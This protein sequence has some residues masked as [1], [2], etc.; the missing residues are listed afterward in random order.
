MAPS[1]ALSTRQHQL[2]VPAG[3][4]QIAGGD[5]R[6]TLGPPLTSLEYSTTIDSSFTLTV[7]VSVTTTVTTTKTVT[8]DDRSHSEESQYF[9]AASDSTIWLGGERPATS[10]ELTTTTSTA[11][12]SPLP[13]TSSNHTRVL[14]TGVLHGTPTKN[15]TDITVTPRSRVPLRALMATTFVPS[16]LQ[17]W[18]ESSQ[19]AT[20]VHG[21]DRHSSKITLISTGAPTIVTQMVNFANQSSRF[22]TG[23]PALTIQ[24]VRFE[25]QNY[26][27]TYITGAPATIVQTVASG[28]GRQSSKTTI[29]RTGSPTTIIQTVK[30]ANE[31]TALTTRSL[32]TV[33]P[34]V[35]SANQTALFGTVSPATSIQRAKCANNTTSASTRR[36]EAVA[37]QNYTDFISTQER[38]RI[39]VRPDVSV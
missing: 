39:R 37:D 4:M 25:A 31:T 36:S 20:V 21:S 3:S 38:I 22:E 15:A 12:V 10:A 18:N 14:G 24:T 16:G 17:G 5:Y 27:A 23:A 11:V 26:T 7:F 6:H 19:P 9:V 29:F 35:R 33:I 30:F 8:A 1:S 32:P 2:A 34:A 28:S 13:I